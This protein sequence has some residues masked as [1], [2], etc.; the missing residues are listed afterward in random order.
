MKYPIGAVRDTV[1]AL[2]RSNAMK[3]T[4]FLSDKQIVRAS[5][6]TFGGKIHKV[7]NVE[8]VLVLGKPNYAERESIKLWKKAGA[9]FAKIQLKFPPVKKK[10]K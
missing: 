8:I 5:R 7:G 10:R 3:A 6:R 1:E 4:K 2:L 9:T